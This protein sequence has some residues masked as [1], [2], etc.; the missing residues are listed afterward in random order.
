M[1]IRDRILEEKSEELKRQIKKDL[2]ILNNK[3][4]NNSETLQRQLK[5]NSEK[6][7]DELRTTVGRMS[8]RNQTNHNRDE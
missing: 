7:K 1:C 3:I 2:E 8:G 6:T 5:E 4:E